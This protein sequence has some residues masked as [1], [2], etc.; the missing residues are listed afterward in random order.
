[1]SDY[2]PLSLEP[3][4]NAGADFLSQKGPTGKKAFHGLPFEIGSDP[5]RCYLGFGAGGGTDS[6]VIPVGAVARKLIV[7]HTLVESRIKEGEVPGRTIANY[8]FRLQGGNEFRVPIRE[9]FEIGVPALW[10]KS[11]VL[12]T[13][14]EKDALMPRFEGRWDW[15]GSRQ[16]EAK[17]VF[18]TLYLWVWDNPHPDRPIETLTIEPGDRKFLVAAITLS[19]LEEHPFGHQGAR[20]VLIRLPQKQ[21]AEKPL[22]LEV[23][24]DRGVASY[25]WALPANAIEEFLGDSLKGWGEPQNY[26]SSP[27]YVE[28]TARPSATITVKNQGEILGSANFGELEK[29]GRVATPRLEL[30]LVDRGRNWVHVTVVDAES[31]KPVPCRVHFRSPEGI[32]YQPHGHP[33]HVNSNLNTWHQDIGGDLRLGQITY[34][35]IDG[36]CQGW[37]PRGEVIV[38]IARGFEYEPLRT[39]VQIR[40]GQR[41]LELELRRWTDMNAKR[42]FSG[43]S[44]VHFL[45]TLGAHLEARAEELNVVNLLQSQWGH[46][47]TNTEDFIGRPSVSDDGKTI[48]Y[49]SQ[50]NRQHLLGHLDLWGLKQPVM[51]WCSDGPPEAELGGTLDETMSGWA[52]QTHAQGGTV[53]VPHFPNPNGEPAVLIATGRADGIEMLAHDPF[54]HLEYYRY[55]NGGYQLPLVGGTDKMDCNVSVGFYRTYAFVPEHQEFNYDNWCASVR[56][57]CTFLSAGPMLAFSVEGA[58]IGDTLRLPP[59]GGTVEV[60]AQAECF[61]PLHTLQIVQQGKVVAEVEEPKGSR[62]LTLKAKVTVQSDNW[63]AA[64][65]GGPGYSGIPH[66]GGWQR[67]MFAHT[68]PIYVACGEGWK[69]YDPNTVQYMLT[70]VERGLAYVRHTAPQRRAGTVSYHHGEEDHLK[71]LERPYHQALEAIH[72]RM[73]ELGIAH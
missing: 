59:G 46:L 60:V 8:V 35:Y 58:Q 45:P 24:V 18:S 26:A 72:R 50:E 31:K 41:E 71:Y 23:E 6:C 27:A 51:P 55:L 13:S 49:C 54:G 11:P 15:I 10:D 69:L 1:M 16:C 25:A 20:E 7:A 43:D 33:G 62:R 36:K 17:Y 44:H 66:Y 73:H 22:A 65:C 42:W 9:F 12:A 57:G 53:I 64:R 19:G 40:P 29:V 28:V 48:V 3:L 34:A 37:L 39:K 47:F 52:D 67:G 61:F 32:P 21:D 14:D 56:A 63:L 2:Q 38:D 30:E 68:S 5:A 4:Y 70:M